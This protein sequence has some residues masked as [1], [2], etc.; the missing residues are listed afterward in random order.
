VHLFVYVPPIVAS[1]RLAKHVPVAKK[2]HST[3]EELFD[4]SFICGPCRVKGKY[5]ISSSQNF[6]LIMKLLCCSLSSIIFNLVSVSEANSVS[7]IR[8]KRVNRAC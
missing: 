8:C 7:I 5:A 4:A 3:I 1:Q 2:A 6:L